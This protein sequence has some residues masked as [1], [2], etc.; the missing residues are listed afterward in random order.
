MVEDSLPTFETFCAHHDVATL[1][2]DQE[3]ARQYED[4]VK[5]YASFASRIH[6]VVTKGPMSA[7]VA[8]RWRTA[9]LKAI[10]SVSTSDALGADGGR[11]LSTIMPMILQNLHSDNEDYIIVLQ[12]RA[13]ASEKTDQD[14]AIQRR[15]STTTV[16]TVDTNVDG[17][18]DPAALSGTTADADRLAEEEVGVLAMQCLKQIFVANNRGQIRLAT[19]AMLRFIR[20]TVALKRP[21]T[22]HTTR[23]G[24]R[25]TWVTT[26]VEIVTRWTPVQDR[27]IILVTAMDSLVRS[28]VTEDNLEQQLMLVT[29]IGWLLG[30]TINMIGLSVM[31]VLLGLIQ[32]ILILLQLGGKGSNVLPHHQQTDGID[33]FN[34]FKIGDETSSNRDSRNTTETEMASSPSATRQ[35]LLIRL[36]KCIGDLATHIYY[37]DQISDMIAAILLRLKPSLRSGLQSPVAAV[38]HPAAAAQAI[39]NSANLREDPET[40]EF[41]S[42]G[43][44]RVTALNSI[45]E[46]LVV[47]NK[48]SLVT[49]AGATGRNRVSVQIW[50]GTQ[51]LLRD[52]DRR[53]RRAYVDALQT[54][55]RLEMSRGDLR[56]LEDK[57]HMTREFSKPKHESHGIESAMAKRAASNASVRSKSSKP[58]SSSFLQLLHLAVYDNALDGAESESDVLLLHLILYSLVDRLG[59]NAVKSGL[60]MIMRLQ[61]DINND[62]LIGTPVGKLN[63]GSLVHGYLLILS[64][65]FE[66]DS[67]VVGYE[68]QTEISRRRQHGLWLE[69]ISVPPLPLD[70]VIAPAKQDNPP[71]PVLIRE[72]IKPFDS[73]PALV[74]QI[75][76]QYA[77]SVVSP[78]A[79]PPTSPGRVFSMP[80]V[81][82]NSP[83]QSSSFE[84]PSNIREEMLADWT[85]D[86]CIAIV[87]K[88]NAH[89]A[90]LHGS[91]TGTT[92]STQ[93]NY[94]AVND[95]SAR[96]ASPSG[97]R[98]PVSATH[99]SG[100]NPQA[101]AE[102]LQSLQPLHQ[103]ESRR[104]SAQ[105]DTSPRSISDSDQPPTLR[106]EDLKK[107]LAGGA[108]SDA[109]SR[110]N[111][112]GAVRSA[113]PLRNSS[114][115]YQAPEGKGGK[116][117]GRTAESKGLG[118]DSMSSGSD[119]IVSAEGFES[120]SEGDVTQS[121]PRSQ[122]QKSH[123]RSH[124]LAAD[125]RQELDN[126]SLEHSP[127]RAHGGSG[128]GDTQYQ[129]A[130]P[131]SRDVN[132]Y[133]PNSSNSAEDPEANIKALKGELVAPS[134]P[135][136]AARGV[137]DNDDDGV[138]PVPP[139]PAGVAQQN[140]LGLGNRQSDGR[141]LN[142]SYDREGRSRKDGSGS[143]VSDGRGIL[144][145]RR[146]GGKGGFDF[147]Q[148]L[149][150]IEV[151]GLGPGDAGHGISKPPY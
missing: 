74:D 148:L 13:E 99:F 54:W 55:L 6:P 41:F 42:F 59:V 62:S 33:L 129:H 151:K 67:T 149:G 35:E 115:A 66:F 94:L 69:S 58:A 132:R 56:V 135:G 86:S 25:N 10:K 21:S 133:R 95:A 52:E 14:A 19:T 37:S 137:N 40:D 45:K 4:I 63:I 28:P 144:K 49:G 18:T 140:S 143:E 2:A 70:K 71:I 61:E 64:D 85:K 119:S 44:A 87:E 1:A 128:G 60:P 98:S 7:P 20:G 97:G 78:P 121:L 17:S 125:Y 127:S 38:E 150:A 36:R 47:A 83:S 31:D 126:R 117:G 92:R 79:S 27:F 29:L 139:L 50:E 65:R 16:R 147:Q 12:Q 32:H 123:G 110:R 96:D 48:R 91:R 82:P 122:V 102:G 5:A 84:L 136:R 120:A 146:S 109:F 72:S 138:P 80:V 81:S 76:I 130:R 134:S 22:A 141:D 57:R 113:S 3:Y 108:L 112:L 30:S 105:N 118:N 68:I 114:N 77:S 8:V 73:C 111:N 75:A 34:D 101:L 124:I 39:S 23:S 107:A 24:S 106:V 104:Y 51:W 11:Q 142:G 53:V 43:T 15:M 88:Q 46:V 103:Y 90:S 9:G 93:N 116:R 145:V 131:G 100:G 26:L 89:T